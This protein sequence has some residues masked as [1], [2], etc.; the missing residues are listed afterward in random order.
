[1]AFLN[2]VL[3]ELVMGIDQVLSPNILCMRVYDWPLSVARGGAGA[4]IGRCGRGVRVPQAL[5]LVALRRSCL[6]SASQIGSR[7]QIFVDTR[8]RGSELA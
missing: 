7:A 8:R 5:G 1:M 2:F 6:R 3:K 4:A